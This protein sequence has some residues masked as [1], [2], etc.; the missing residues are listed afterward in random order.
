MP[1]PWSRCSGRCHL[2]GPPSSA[3]LCA[4]SGTPDSMIS[5]LTNNNDG[6]IMTRQDHDVNEAKLKLAI[7][8]ARDQ[9][10]IMEE[11]NEGAT[12]MERCFW[13]MGAGVP[14]PQS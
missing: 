10:G 4:S 8:G 11:A 6:A 1:A 5:P 3:S 14:P 2:T 7:D 9:L 13:L 12:D